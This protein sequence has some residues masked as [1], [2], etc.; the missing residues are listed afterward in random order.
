MHLHLDVET[1]SVADLPEVGAYRYAMDS[2]THVLLLSYA[3]DD[4][5]VE[6]ID[7]KHGEALPASLLSLLSD[8]GVLK[9]A[10]NAEFER[11]ILENVL[12]IPCPPEQWR[13]TAVWARYLGLPASLGDLA[14]ELGLADQ[15][16]KA[17][18]RLIKQFSIL[19][20][21]AKKQTGLLDV[22]DWQAFIRYNRQD[23]T[24][25]RSV[26]RYMGRWPVPDRE[27]TLWAL[28]Q[29]INGRG[30]P[31]DLP[32]VRAAFDLANA[33]HAATVE[34]TGRLT[35]L[36]K[37]N[38]RTQLMGWLG[39]QGITVTDLQ[40]GTVETLLKRMDLPPVVR[41]VLEN[42]QQLA[43]ASLAKYGALLEATPDD[44]RI[45]GTMLFYGA[46][47][48]GRW[49][50]RLFQPQN[51]PRG[52]IS[53]TDVEDARKRVLRR[54]A[55]FINVLW[56]D[57]SGVLSSLV[58]SAIH[59]PA[60]Q[61]LC[62]ADYSSIES[63]MLAWAAGSKY[64]LDLF[65][66]KR[67]PYKDF[68]TR[69]FNVAYEDVTKAMRALSKPAKLGCG[70]NM[71]PSALRAYAQGMGI[72]LSEQD[73][74][75]HVDTY[76]TSYPEIPRLWSDFEDA[77]F[78]AMQGESPCAGPFRFHYDKPFLFIDLPSG[79]SLSYYRA[80][81]E[82]NRG[83]NAICY[84]GREPGGKTGKVFTY[85]G[86]IVENVVQAISRDVLANG[87]FQV[88][89]DPDLAIVGHVHDEIV[90][91]ARA[92]DE[93]ALDRLIT[94]MTT[95]PA[96]CPDAPIRASGWRGDYFRKD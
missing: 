19:K 52:S 87:L 15:K 64:L 65:W 94:A 12:R 44:G 49:S 55:E 60:G 24:V 84:E 80:A 26:A 57:V 72:D 10:H 89:Q 68:A 71:G 92:D 91:T 70:Y 32:F 22:E 27:W 2:S 30:L 6:T 37:P 34:H 43:Q 9:W 3:V 54:D 47:R 46:N 1:A 66:A 86:K 90:V 58:R 4:G 40:A 67:D 48:S 79:R 16:D 25:E 69:L 77:A 85:G 82:N 53:E 41:T 7:L 42:R 13:C 21:G 39:Q 63:V 73:A 59:A 51:L 35:G 8:P 81:I 45:R 75:R 33:N 17:G 61:V 11:A 95:L 20:P 56:G 36:K 23:V 74:K 28:D 88:T 76:R 5:G 50:G 18:I 29:T 14:A 93:T 62:A 83:R 96:W 78:Q 31:I 38:S